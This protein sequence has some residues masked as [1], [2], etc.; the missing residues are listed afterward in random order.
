MSALGQS[1]TSRSGIPGVR[2]VPISDI[3]TFA[4]LG[5]ELAC[6]EPSPRIARLALASAASGQREHFK[7]RRAGTSP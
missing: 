3:A 4:I 6:S 1:Q 7:K 5:K 2:K